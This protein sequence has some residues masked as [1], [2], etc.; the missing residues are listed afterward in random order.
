MANLKSSKKRILQSK[1]KRKHNNS[2]KSMLKTFIKKT[3]FIINSGDK[4]EA[5]KFFIKTQ[6]ILDRQSLKKIIHKN[7]VSRLKSNLS[8][9]INN[10]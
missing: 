9:K 2:Y 7:K 5:K 8:I 4:N 3:L 6:K 10:M 1:K